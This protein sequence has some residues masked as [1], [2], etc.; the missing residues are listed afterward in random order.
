MLLRCPGNTSMAYCHVHAC[1]CVV[2][3]TPV[4]LIAMCMHAAALSWQH[5]YGLLP[6]AC[7]LLRCPDNTSM[8]YCHVHACCCV[9]LT[10]PV[11]LIAMCMH[12][13]A[14]SWQYQYGLLPCACMLLRC[15]GNTSMAYCHVHACCC[16]VLATP[17][18]L[19]AMCMHA[20][21]LSWQHQYGLLPCACML[22]RCPVNTSM[23]YC[24]VHACCCV[25]LSTPVWLTAM[26]MHAAAL[27]C[28]HQ[29]GLLPCACMLL[30]CPVNTS[31][32]YCHVHACCCVVLSTPL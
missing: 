29:Y 4:W 7:M 18:W 11:W 6:C 19:I 10:I 31:M 30:R 24:H 3:A 2:L 15:P 32:A 9:V 20:A 23:A 5:Q 22:L 26:C 27:S 8:A 17:V 13:A 16:V 14:L 21:A 1:C 12:A 25:V 28:Q